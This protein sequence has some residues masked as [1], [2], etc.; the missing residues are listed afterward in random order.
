MTEV[1]LEDAQMIAWSRAAGPICADFATG[2]RIDGQNLD[3]CFTGWDGRAAVE[4]P[5][6]GLGLTM[7]ADPALAFLVV[8]VPRG[9]DFFCAE[10]VSNANASVNLANIG[11]TD[12]GLVTLAPG[13]SMR[14]SV[15]FR[16]EER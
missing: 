4:W 13:A 9:E 10:P 7:L 6:R 15:R 14:G 12:H 2:K 5:E 8:Y 1:W 16:V 11:V 3:N